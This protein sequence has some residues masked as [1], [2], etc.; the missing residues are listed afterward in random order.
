MPG[1]HPVELRQRAVQTYLETDLTQEE[2]AE[3]F[4]VG[5][6]SVRRWF[7]RHRDAG[8]VEPFQMGGERRSKLSEDD[9]AFVVQVVE[10]RP[11]ITIAEI[12]E[13]VCLVREVDI[14]DSC[15]VRALKRLGFSRKKGI[16]V[17]QNGTGLTSS[18]PGKSYGIAREDSPAGA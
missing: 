18:A 4:R 16:Y 1:P 13:V 17:R 9:E 6:A 7:W 5:V 14:S 10:M 11:D 15:I 3:L 2:V 12:T 8:H